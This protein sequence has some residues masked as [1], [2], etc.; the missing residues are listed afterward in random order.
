MPSLGSEVCIQN[1]GGS[2]H[3]LSQ[4]PGP[5]P[6]DLVAAEGHARRCYQVTLDFSCSSPNPAVN[7]SLEL[8]ET[9][10]G[11]IVLR[12]PEQR[13]TTGS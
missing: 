7:D 11:S 12:F 3:D 9:I 10:I 8:P 5:I 1:T 4:F 13:Q 6:N 2:E